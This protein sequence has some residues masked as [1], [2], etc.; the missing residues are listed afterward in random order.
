MHP[1]DELRILDI[2][3]WME[4]PELEWLYDRGCQATVAVELGV[5]MGRSAC[6]VAAGQRNVRGSKL[7]AI[8]TFDGRGTSRAEEV[9][10]QEPSWLMMRFLDN[11]KQRG[12]DQVLDPTIRAWLSST[13]E[14]TTLAAIEDGSVDFLFI[15]AS[16]DYQS[17]RR[18]LRLWTPKVRPGGI[19]AG[20][21]YHPDWP[22]VV[23]AVDEFFG[24]NLE[25]RRVENPVVGIWSVQL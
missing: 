12:F 19:A 21:D 15:D 18:D 25:A 24:E 5:F 22:G 20:H 1:I 9:A 10:A 6:A 8:D 16:H 23:Q 4:R 14:P 17:V 7:Y 11:L 2:E 13:D 3:G